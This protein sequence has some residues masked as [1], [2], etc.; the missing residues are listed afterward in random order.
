[1]DNKLY[2]KEML[3][4]LSDDV[5]N[6]LGILMKECKKLRK[7]KPVDNSEYTTREFVE[8]LKKEENY[9]LTEDQLL[10]LFRTT[11]HLGKQENNFNIPN[12]GAFKS[13]YFTSQD[14]D[15]KFTAYGYKRLHKVAMKKM[16]EVRTISR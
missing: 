14:K 6:D 5:F 13:G 9:E 4:A 8:K 3:L 7:V 12:D 1:M 15:F 11:T 10:W 16:D 2:T